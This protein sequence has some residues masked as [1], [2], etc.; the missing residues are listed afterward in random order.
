MNATKYCYSPARHFKVIHT[1][2]EFI[3]SSA[4]NTKKFYETR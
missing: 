4:D 3:G 1:L 2:A